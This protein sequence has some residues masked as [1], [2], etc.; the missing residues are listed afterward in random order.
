MRVTILGT[1]P[2]PPALRGR[3]ASVRR[4]PQVPQ[5][6][7]RREIPYCIER[8]WVRQGNVYHG[9]F[10]TAYGGF[11]GMVEDRGWGDL[12]FYMFDPPN[13]VR[14]SDHWACFA[15]RGKKGFHVHMG[16]RPADVSS[17]ILTIERLLTESFESNRR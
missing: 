9:T 17:G 11:R 4:A 3:G 10:Q 12:R 16:R 1:R 6:V 7:A 14:R 5:R 15:P 13:A 2:A 8:G